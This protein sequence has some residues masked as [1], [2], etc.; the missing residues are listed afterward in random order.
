MNNNDTNGSF[1]EDLKK[2]FPVFENVNKKVFYGF[3]I[4][5]SIAL[6]LGIVAIIYF[7]VG[8]NSNTIQKTTSIGLPVNKN[9]FKN[10]VTISGFKF[11]PKE[12]TINEGETVT[13]FNFD[14]AFHYVTFDNYPSLSS[15]GPIKEDTKF[16]IKFDKA[17]V[18]EYHCPK[19]DV[20]FKGERYK[21]I[22]KPAAEQ[23]TL[24][25]NQ[26]K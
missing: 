18:Y 2:K 21:V 10:Q 1:Y 14:K 26:S 9:M 25:G 15:K 11:D 19:H 17:G 4:I 6:V 7:A 5:V 24:S 22:V 13:W 16:Q 3:N 8:S 12:I 20:Y 23:T